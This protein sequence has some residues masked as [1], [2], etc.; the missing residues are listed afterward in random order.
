MLVD[1]LGPGADDAAVRPGAGRPRLAGKPRSGGWWEARRSRRPGS[2][3]G[4]GP[5][6]RSSRQLG[7][8][9]EQAVGVGAVVVVDQ[10]RPQ[11]AAA[12]ADAKQ[13]GQLPGVVVPVPDV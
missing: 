11:R 2:W 3:A 7:D 6:P 5:G 4:P 8:G 12:L 9:A 13:P 10:A 1:Q